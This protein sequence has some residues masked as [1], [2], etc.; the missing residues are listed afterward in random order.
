MAARLVQRVLPGFCVLHAPPVAQ[1]EHTR[2][3]AECAEY[4]REHRD[5][6]GCT[7]PAGRA[8]ERDHEIAGEQVQRPRRGAA[9]QRRD[10]HPVRD[11]RMRS[12]V[13]HHQSS[14]ER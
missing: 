5:R 11:L 12:L 1:R 8:R 7:V 9:Q 13:R 6:R 10:L 14:G 4:D 2:G 3:C